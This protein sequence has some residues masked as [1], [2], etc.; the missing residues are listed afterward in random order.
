[1][2]LDAAVRLATPGTLLM[3]PPAAYSLQPPASGAAPAVTAP[4]AITEGW[5]HD[6]SAQDPLEVL[7]LLR[8]RLRKDKPRSKQPLPALPVLLLRPRSLRHPAR[9]VDEPR[10][11]PPVRPVSPWRTQVEPPRAHREPPVPFFFWPPPNFPACAST[12]LRR[13]TG[14]AVVKDDDQ[15]TSRMASRT[16]SGT[17]G[18]G[19]FSCPF[20]VAL[21]GGS[22]G[23]VHE[24]CRRHNGRARRCRGD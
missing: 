23:P 18:N 14:F 24:M 16:L 7:L 3:T 4:S 15:T 13:R 8:L 17:E 22:S 10:L 21:S 19:G 1:M 12:E 5:D 6:L 2:P 11:A 9:R 20:H